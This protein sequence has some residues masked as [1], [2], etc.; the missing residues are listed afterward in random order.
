MVTNVRLA[1]KPIEI[2]G[3]GGEPVRVRHKG[4]LMGHGMVYHPAEVVANIS[5]LHESTKDFNL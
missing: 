1:K 4:D 5:A 3:I 2:T